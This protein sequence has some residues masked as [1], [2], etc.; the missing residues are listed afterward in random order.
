MIPRKS[1]YTLYFVHNRIP[2]SS[3]TPQFASKGYARNEPVL[4]VVGNSSGGAGG[5]PVPPLHHHLWMHSM[6]EKV[7]QGVPRVSANTLRG[8]STRY[9]K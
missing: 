8:E 6:K 2:P 5:A 3:E 7:I 4:V 1:C 9:S